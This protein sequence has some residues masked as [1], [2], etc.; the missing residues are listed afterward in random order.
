MKQVVLACS[1]KPQ[2]IIDVIPFVKETVFLCFSLLYLLVWYRNHYFRGRYPHGNWYVSVTLV[3]I[4]AGPI[5]LV[6]KYLED[7]D[8][9][10][11]FNRYLLF[12][13]FL[14]LVMYLVVILFRSSL[15]ST[16]ITER[17]ARLS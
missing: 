16:E 10:F 5:V 14:S 4:V 7:E 17:K 11:V 6:R 13:L 8:L 12:L 1:Y 3:F 15:T 9:F 2:Q